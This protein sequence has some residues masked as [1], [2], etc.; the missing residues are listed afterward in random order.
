LNWD[1]KSLKM[2]ISDKFTVL[3]SHTYSLAILLHRWNMKYKTWIW[4]NMH[5]NLRRL[6]NN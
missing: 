3:A 1:A 5:G 6:W 2:R 4:A